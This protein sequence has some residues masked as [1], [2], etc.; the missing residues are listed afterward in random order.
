[1]IE[2]NAASVEQKRTFGVVGI[3]P[4]AD[5]GTTA[6]Q[7]MKSD[8]VGPSR[9]R[10]RLQPAVRAATT[11][12]AKR[13]NGP[14]PFLGMVFPP[15]ISLRSNPGLNP[16]EPGVPWSAYNSPILFAYPLLLEHFGKLPVPSRGFGKQHQTRRVPVDTMEGPRSFAQVG[17]RP[18]SQALLSDPGS[19]HQHPIRLSQRQEV[20]VLVDYSDRVFQDRRQTALRSWRRQRRL[21]AGQVVELNQS[22]TGGRSDS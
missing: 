21:F 3:K 22:N 18:V 7:T 6:L 11:Q 16:A 20:F 1:M 4:V 2:S 19:L 17:A 8:L 5:N 10:K 9:F 14:L 12:H 15:S 13:R